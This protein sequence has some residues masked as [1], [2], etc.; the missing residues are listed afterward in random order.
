MSH[1]QGQSPDVA[2]RD[3]YTQEEAIV[4]WHN[5]PT[6]LSVLDPPIPTAIVRTATTEKPGL[7]RSARIAWV[8]SDIT[9]HVSLSNG[10]AMRD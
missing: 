7:L 9:G 3:G 8:T 6:S 2:V 1:V 5:R 10:G 4:D